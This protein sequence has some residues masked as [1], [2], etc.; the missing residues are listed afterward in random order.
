MNKKIASVIT[1]IMMLLSFWTVNCFADAETEYVKINSELA[2]AEALVDAGIIV[3]YQDGELHLE[4]F[5]TRTEFTK[6]IVA[7][8]LPNDSERFPIIFSDV[9]ADFWGTPYIEQAVAAG[10]I[11]GFE[12]NTFRPDDKVTYEQAIKIVIRMLSGYDYDSYPTDYVQMAIDKG[13]A[14]GMTSVIGESIT[15]EEA[16][17]LIYNALKYSEEYNAAEAEDYSWYGPMVNGTVGIGSKGYSVTGG[18]ALAVEDGLAVDGFAE[19]YNEPE[20]GFYDFNTEEYTKNDENVFKSAVT[21]PLSTF[22]IDADTASYSNMRRYILQSGMLPPSGS[23]RTEELINYFSFDNPAP[24]GD[25]PFSVTASMH[26]CPW[27]EG[28][29]LAKIDVQGTESEQYGNSNLVFLVDISGSMFDFN[30][31]PLVKKSLKMLLEKLNDT[32]TVSIVTYASGTRVVLESTPVSEKEKIISA[33]DELRAGGG[34]YGEAGI[35]LAYEQA[36]KNIIDGN[37]R[38]ILCTDGD[39]NIG[40][41]STGD[42]KNLIEEKRDKGIYLTVL[43]FGMGNYKDSK[44]ETLADYGNGNYA[45]IDSA[46]EAKKVFVDEMPKTIYA[47]A[48]DVKIQVEFN[49]AKVKEYRLIGYENR[50]LNNE[51]FEN[52]KRDAGEL[53][54]G[55]TVTALYEIVP[56]NGEVDNTLKY[57]QSVLTESDEYMTVK[58]RYKDPDGSESKLIELPVSESDNNADDGEFY[59]AAAVAELGMILNNSEFIGTSTYESVISLAREGLENDEFGFR[60]EFIH[61]VDL[62]KYLDK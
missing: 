57:Q 1:A 8:F 50:V 7:A 13:I 6:M 43:G 54:A 55:A 59:F 46:R 53:G 2:P 34:T 10:V 19:V 51:D 25:L 40:N 20:L 49:P 33:L 28:N 30:K 29:L 62:M 11:N 61:L 3:G 12:D 52:D 37:N 24:E 15:R 42:L 38:I 56:A 21:S 16:V 27:N 44:M 41:S 5:L 17:S 35:N 36:E 60:M 18:A 31:L 9:A 47:I 23:I 48:K 32:D 4:N 26:K 39:F 58:L 45:Y 14:D 22:S